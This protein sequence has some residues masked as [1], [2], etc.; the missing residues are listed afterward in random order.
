M[1]HVMVDTRVTNGYLRLQ[2]IPLEDD[3]EVKVIVIPK[4]NLA[5][6]SFQKAQQLA[7]SIKGN[8]SHDMISERSEE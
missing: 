4:A 3:T 8:I 6:M 2:D 1:S 7:K 5:K